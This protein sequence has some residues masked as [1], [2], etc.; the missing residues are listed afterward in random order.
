MTAVV[1]QFDAKQEAE[2]EQFHG[3]DGVWTTLMTS[4]VRDNVKP[5]DMERVLL[6]VTGDPVGQ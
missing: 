6:D 1:W 3:A 5:K 2:F 4:N